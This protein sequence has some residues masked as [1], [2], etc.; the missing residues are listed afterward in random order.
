MCAPC[1]SRAD[2]GGTPAAKSMV[3][4]NLIVFGEDHLPEHK[5]EQP[6]RVAVLEG[7]WVSS[8]DVKTELPFICLHGT[9]SL[10]IN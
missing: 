4:L 6:S 2:G 7:T 10:Q 8:S 5:S 1:F 3:D 9:L